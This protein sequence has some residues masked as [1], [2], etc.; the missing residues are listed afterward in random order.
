MFKYVT[1][2]TSSMSVVESIV[3]EIKKWIDKKLELFPLIVGF[4]YSMNI[5]PIVIHVS[6]R[7][8]DV[9]VLELKQS[10]S[11]IRRVLYSSSIEDVENPVI[12]DVLQIDRYKSDICS[13]IQSMYCDRYVQFLREF[14]RSVD[15]KN[16]QK[17]AIVLRVCEK[18]KLLNDSII[19]V[20]MRSDILK[21]WIM[22]VVDSLRDLGY[23]VDSKAIEDVLNLTIKDV[24]DRSLP[25]GYASLNVLIIPACLEDYCNYII[26]EYGNVRRIF[27]IT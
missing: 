9:D 27:S 21:G 3:D 19:R 12:R 4:I 26:S 13:R 15:I 20:S 24:V 22:G 1:L 17:L 5:D 11:N 25:I 14:E 8:K 23:S 2:N 18:Q 7:M 10:L 6:E 16:I